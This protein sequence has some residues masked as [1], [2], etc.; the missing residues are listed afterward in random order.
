MFRLLKKSSNGMWVTKLSLYFDDFNLCRDQ[1]AR[2]EM[3]GIPFRLEKW[4]YRVGWCRCQGK[5][6]VVE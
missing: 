4:V 3:R 2:F 5:R 6:P 1:M